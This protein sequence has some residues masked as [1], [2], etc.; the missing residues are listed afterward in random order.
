LNATAGNTLVLQ[1]LFTQIMPGNIGGGGGVVQLAGATLAASYGGYGLQPGNIS[2]YGTVSAPVT[3]QSTITADGL[4]TGPQTLAFTNTINSYANTGGMGWFA[5]H[6]GELSLPAVNVTAAGAYNWG[7]D[8][9]ALKLVNSIGLTFGGTVTAGSLAIALLSPDR[10]DV[11]AG[12]TN[13]IG[14][15]SFAADP[16]TFG[17]VALTFRYDDALAGSLGIDQTTL[18]LYGYDGTQWV[19]LGDTVDT[20]NKLVSS[21]SA[22]SAFYQDFA[23]AQYAVPEPATLGLLVLGGLGMLA[24]RRNIGR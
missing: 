18:Q 23:I 10:S 13:P 19:N 11:P 20:T 1:G 12:L 21:A 7:G 5:Q 9:V 14:V 15:W 4:G 6:Q 2:G 8:P 24:R 17:S 22:L 16:L 3:T